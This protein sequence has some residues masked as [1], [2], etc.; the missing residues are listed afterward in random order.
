[1][2]SFLIIII[3][4][5]RYT[6]YGKIIY[7]GEVLKTDETKEQKNKNGVISRKLAGITA[8]EHEAW[9]LHKKQC[10]DRLQIDLRAKRNDR[11]MF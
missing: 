4:H 5:Y 11:H 1:M 8:N 10:L 7:I 9:D 2:I 6:E 3:L